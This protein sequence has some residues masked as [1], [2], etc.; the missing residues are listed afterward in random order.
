MYL[1]KNFFFQLYLFLIL[2]CFSVELNTPLAFYGTQF[3][4]VAM[5]VLC[6]L[7]FYP[8]ISIIKIF[9][10][11]ILVFF[12]ELL[13]YFQSLFTLYDN[14]FINSQKSVFL[15]MSMFLISDILIAKFD[16]E[17]FLNAINMYILF[18]GSIV[19]F[20]FFAFY[21]LGMPKESL[22]LSLL[23]G[24]E[25]S[26]TGY[27]DA[28]YRPTSV[29]PEPAIFVG[30]QISLLVLQYLLKKENN[31]IRLF[32][33]VS[34]LMSM[35]FAGVLLVAIYGTFVYINKI[36]NIVFY[37]IFILIASVFLNQ[38]FMDRYN[39]ILSGDDGSNGV[40]L[41]IINSF[42][43]SSNYMIFGYGNVVANE[44][45]P[46]FFEGATDLTF[47]ATVFG[48]YG[49]FIGFCVLLIFFCWLYTSK[50]NFREKIII[51]IPLIKLT[52][53]GVIFFSCFI[54]LLLIIN[55]GRSNK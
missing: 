40:K 45:T 26:R 19:F 35:S 14:L 27:L 30:V 1:K 33:L 31:I 8:K 53:P 20:Q 17:V 39:N 24:G 49:L 55:R 41:E 13:I 38:I 47:F 51:L 50:F 9:I 46:K 7:I 28:L 32:G 37:L 18:I 12:W 42:L 15:F 36:R 52:N 22:D 44:K 21:F 6:R 10:I 43:S 2:F 3:F 34:I 48:V 4:G 29:M 54:F 16:K 11:T 5:L 25:S 23:L